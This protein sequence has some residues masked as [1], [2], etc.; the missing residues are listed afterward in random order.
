MKRI[1]LIVNFEKRQAVDEVK[2]VATLAA[3]MGFD[4]YADAATAKLSPTINLCD[5]KL[6][7]RLGVEGVVV[8][9]G[10]GT[11]LDASHRL[12][13]PGLPM[14]GLNMGS[15]GYLTSVESAHFNEAL[16]QLREDRFTVA[17]RTA[18]AIRIVRKDGSADTLPDALNDAVADHGARAK[19]VDLELLLDERPVAQFLCDGII[20][21]T[22]TGSTAYSLSAGGPIVMPDAAVL[23]VNVIC[24]HTLTFRPLVVRDTTRVAIRV[25]HCPVP[26]VLSSDGRDNV[27]LDTGDCVEVARSP[28]EVP[29][30]EL[31]GY[32]PCDVLRRKLRW[33]HSLRRDAPEQF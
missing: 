31:N 4:L 21:A 24:P 5:P 12:S 23:V 15:L 29:V 26:M 22:P 9:G 20:V 18:L 27:R 6:F 30:I 8:L 14:M 3:G 19:P 17:S 28:N 1:G 13:G 2:R 33:G 7:P 10:D 11:M 16:Q 25:V 32:N